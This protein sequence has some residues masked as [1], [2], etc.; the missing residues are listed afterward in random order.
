MSSAELE[1]INKH[2]ENLTEILSSSKFSTSLKFITTTSSHTCNLDPIIHLEQ[3]K[4]YEVALTS[5]ST[6]NTIQN[7]IKDV[8]DRFKYSNDKGKTWKELT[9]LPGS[10]EVESI[11]NEIKRHLGIQFKDKKQLHFAVEPAVN[12][13]SLTLDENHQVDFDIDKSLSRLLGFKK[14]LYAQGFHISENIPKITEINSINVQCD[15]IE[16]GYVNGKLTN[17]IFSYPA[18]TVPIGYSLNVIPKSLIYFPVTRKTI[19]SITIRITDEKG[20]A[21]NFGGEE[22]MIDL[23]LREV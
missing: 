11:S 2:L 20:K 16:G 18:F 3:E 21:I 22:I 7:I 8:N 17:N 4:H 10:Y 5:F 15:I 6:F 12:K 19:N 9:F 14:K 23:L 1:K 13:F